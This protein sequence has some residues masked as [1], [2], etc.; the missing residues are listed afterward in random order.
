L[1]FSAAACAAAEDAGVVVAET[2]ALGMSLPSTLVTPS[3]VSLLSISVPAIRW[4][5]FGPAV[6]VATR[7]YWVCP[8]ADGCES[9]LESELES[10]LRREEDWACSVPPDTAGRLTCK[11]VGDE[12][13]CADSVAS[14]L[15][16]VGSALPPHPNISA[17]ASAMALRFRALDLN[18]FM[19]ELLCLTR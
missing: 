6:T 7:L 1:S 8:I 2:A 9:S 19:I 15:P 18:G 10:D 5:A 11:A 14:E 17:L 3:S 12:V 16:V 4:P 13:N